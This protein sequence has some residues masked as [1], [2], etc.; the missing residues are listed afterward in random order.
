MYR[1]SIFNVQSAK[2]SS[3]EEMRLFW[4]NETH[5]LG[6]LKLQGNR[7]ILNLEWYLTASGNAANQAV[8]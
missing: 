4:R 3:C 1:A 7:R 5:E 8:I 2:F 6:E